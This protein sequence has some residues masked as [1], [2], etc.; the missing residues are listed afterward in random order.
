MN[1]TGKNILAQIDATR[2]LANSSTGNV[3]NSIKNIWMTI[4]ESDPRIQ[5]I[6][7]KPENVLCIKSILRIYFLQQWY[8]RWKRKEKSIVH[9]LFPKIRIPWGMTIQ[10]LT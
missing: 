8:H 3:E 2:S 10:Q 9:N 6:H 4:V 5:Q 1:V 7:H